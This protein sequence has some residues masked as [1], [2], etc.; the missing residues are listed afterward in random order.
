[1]DTSELLRRKTTAFEAIRHSFG[2]DAGADSIDLFVEHHIEEIPQDYW[3]RQLG[4]TAPEPKAVLELLQLEK[5]WGTNDMEYFDFTLPEGV[6]QYVVSVHF[7][8]DGEID[9]VSMES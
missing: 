8:S 7:G 1:V 2:T 9:S 5:S 6:T 3:V 4:T